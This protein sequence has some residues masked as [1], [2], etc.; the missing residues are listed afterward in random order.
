MRSPIGL[1]PHMTKMKVVDM[2]TGEV[3]QSV[4]RGMMLPAKEGTCEWCAVEHK[5]NLPHDATSMFYQYRFYNENGRWPDWRD[6]L[7]HCLDKMKE[8]WKSE[9]KKANIDVDKG[10]VR[11][12][13]K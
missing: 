8:F 3:T 13:G 4:S 6:A 7:A 12:G 1:N 10:Q 5:S 9:L 2:K 11:P